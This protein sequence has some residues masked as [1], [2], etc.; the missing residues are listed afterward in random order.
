MGCLPMSK[1]KQL[2][3]GILPLGGKANI[4]L[5]GGMGAAKKLAFLITLN[6][7]VNNSVEFDGIRIVLT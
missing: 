1:P 6:R 7:C 5:I 3:L 2:G 4:L